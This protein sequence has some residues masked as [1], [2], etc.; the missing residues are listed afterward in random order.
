MGMPITVSIAGAK[1]PTK[2]FAAVYGLFTA[3]DDRF[4]TYKPDSEVSRINR[5]LPEREWSDDMRT[6]LRL[7]DETKQLTDGYFDARHNG[8]LDPSGLVKGWA[9][10]HAAE[11]LRQRGSMNFYID[12]GGD[13]QTDG[14][15]ADDRP[16]QVG[17]RNPF[18]REE[19]VKVL[20]LSGEG[21]ATSGAYIRGDHIYNPHAA[22]GAPKTVA[23]MTV[24]G[25]NVYEADR[26]VTAAYAM[27][28]KGIQFIE[29]L[30]GFEGYMIDMHG[31]ATMTSNFE[32]YITHL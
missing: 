6:V 23:S 5:G 16:W 11:L 28:L 20:S 4:S 26:F 27:G 2:L 3:I 9:I 13:I 10:Q 17:I 32:R 8:R 29:R 24:I 1:D 25:P 7:C 21:V 30:E 31:T 14:H 12:A 18:K 22:H 19:I 15:A